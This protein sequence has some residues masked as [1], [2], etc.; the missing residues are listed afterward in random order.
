M[1]SLDCS[2]SGNSDLYGLGIRI[3]IYL[4]ITSTMITNHFVPTSARSNLTANLI[5]VSALV[6]AMIRS[7]NFP[8][9]FYFVEGFVLLQLILAFFLGVT[10][11]V[12][13]A[14][15]DGFTS[16]LDGRI[17]AQTLA[18][19]KNV[20]DLEA[21]VILSRALSKLGRTYADLPPLQV[22]YREAL[23]SMTAALNL[24]FWISGSQTLQH[25]G[26]DCRTYIFFFAPVSLS[27]AL[28]SLFIAIAAVYLAFHVFNLGLNL[29]ISDFVAGTP[30]KKILLRALDPKPPS[31]RVPP[32]EAAGR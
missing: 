30:I 20:T 24:W 14:F 27:S 28:R 17:T 32:K 16:F 1:D 18:A 22:N 26:A 9:Q 11:G 6:I 12:W 25:A 23:I 15:V 8:Q 3:G 31:E 13:F 7:I 2:I 5:F 29:P 19:M 4:Q 21:Q 10:S